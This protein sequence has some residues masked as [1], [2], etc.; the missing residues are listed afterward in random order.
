M[1]IKPGVLAKLRI[2]KGLSQTQ[3]AKKLKVS[4]QSISR[5]E[6]T[7][8]AHI[9]GPNQEKIANFFEVSRDDIRTATP[10]VYPVQQELKFEPDPKEINNVAI[11]ISVEK[12][13]RYRQK[14]IQDINGMDYPTLVGM[15]LEEL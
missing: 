9:N 10:T 11:N 6:T 7:K 14:L 5:W 8:N 15:M 2:K 12:I 3:L 4:H 13:E 1:Y